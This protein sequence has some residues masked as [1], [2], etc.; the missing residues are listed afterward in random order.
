MTKNTLHK[1]KISFYDQHFKSFLVIILLTLGC[2]SSA[3]PIKESAEPWPLKE[4]VNEPPRH[5]FEDDPYWGKL[6]TLRYVDKI[7][8]NVAAIGCDKNFNRGIPNGHATYAYHVQYIN[9]VNYFDRHE[10]EFITC[11]R[12]PVDCIKPPLCMNNNYINLW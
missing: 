3:E 11:R 10:P 2:G 5:S 8:T 7:K 6:L 9:Q 12:S 4:E 1:T